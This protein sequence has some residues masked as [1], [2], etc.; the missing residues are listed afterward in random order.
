VQRGVL[1]GASNGRPH[2]LGR[3]PAILTAVLHDGRW[4]NRTPVLHVVH[5][6]R[7]L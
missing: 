3:R 7:G 2:T 4:P 5:V 1:A 6:G